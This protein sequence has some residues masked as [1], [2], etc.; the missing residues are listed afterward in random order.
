MFLRFTG[1]P[2]LKEVIARNSSVA[3]TNY[4]RMEILDNKD[5]L[6]FFSNHRK[7]ELEFIIIYNK[8]QGRKSFLFKG[9]YQERLKRYSES[10]FL[11]VSHGG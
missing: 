5:H 9:F 6:E 2:S 4:I 8:L 11:R 1:I 10:C 7:K 3:N